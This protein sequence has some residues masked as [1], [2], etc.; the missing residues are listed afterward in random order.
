MHIYYNFRFKASEEKRMS[1][2]L[3]FTPLK[4]FG[5]VNSRVGAGA[6]AGTAGAGAASKFS[7]GARAA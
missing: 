1:D 5:L 4:I 2:L 3:R 6:G 7:P